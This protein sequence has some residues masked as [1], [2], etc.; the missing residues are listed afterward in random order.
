MAHG[1]RSLHGAVF[2]GLSVAAGAI[3]LMIVAIHIFGGPFAPQPSV[4][5]AIG[6][7]AADIRA[8]ALR[9]LNG[10]P[11]QAAVAAPWDI[12]RALALA[13]PVM[14]TLAPIAATVSAVR[15]ETRRPLAFGAMLGAAALALQL[16]WWIAL[17]FAGAILLYAIL[18]NMESILG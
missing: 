11:R 10:A 6:G 1:G 5:E 4:G 7:I 9:S 18:A 2:G 17:L 8:S 15:R 12:D 3:A 16:V 13:G 14:A